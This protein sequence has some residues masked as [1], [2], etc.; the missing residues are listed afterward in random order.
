MLIACTHATSMNKHIQI[1]NVDSS[2]HRKLKIRAVENGTSLSE[3]LKN[4]LALIARRPSNK[5][6]LAKLRDMKPVEG[7][8]NTVA[9]IREDREQR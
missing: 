5:E 4:E 7:D 3:Y 2:L 9:Y 1:K 8:L 6:L